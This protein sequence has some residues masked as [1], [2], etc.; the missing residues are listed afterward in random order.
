MLAQILSSAVNGIDAYL[1][2]V[3]VDI[4]PALPSFT[5]VG[6]PDAAVRESIERVRAA[7][8]NCGLEFP[9]RRITINLAP[10]DV[11]KEGPSF[12]LPI[13]VGILAATGQVDAEFVKDCV[14][15]GELSLDGAVRTVSGV[16]P[17]ALNARERK[18]KRMIVPAQNVKEAAIVGDVDVY[19]VNTLTEVVQLLNEPNHM[20]PAMF[21][22]KEFETLDDPHYDIDFSDVKGQENVK[23]ALEIAAAGGHNII[24]IGPPG[25]G[26]TMLARR[27]PT[28]LPPMSLDEALETTKLYSVCG[29]LSSKEALVTRR[30]F[31]APHHTIS[32]AGLTGGGTYPRP[33]EVSLAH[34]GVLFLDELPEFRR[35]VLEVL[36]QPLEDGTVTIARAQAS[37]TYPARFV[38]VAALNPCPCGFFGDGSKPCTCTPQMIQRYLQRVSGPL[39]DRIDIHI[40][41]SRLKQDEL[42]GKGTGESSAAIRQR[43]TAARSR[44]LQRLAGSNIF[45][46]AHMSS[47]QLKQ[48]CHV[49]D[50]TKNLLRTAINQLNLSARA[51]DRILKL[52]RTIAD[53]AGEDDVQTPH[54]AEAIQYRSLD[55]KFWG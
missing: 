40:E 37:L 23:R 54:I 1:I 29:L 35:D 18:M 55:R 17:I 14:I 36:R 30:A 42:L 9:S 8:K 34:H 16:L 5:I 20:L 31:R 11:R 28:I 39:L 51:Y 27:I 41:V 21:D 15:V 24:M 48:F 43:V 2:E 44:Q 22:I 25:S 10:A 6:L 32:N 45:C 50:D 19:P 46:N 13:A 26:K 3:E 53:L 38:M 52:A 49:S 47:K 4:T 33:G 12:D 7:I